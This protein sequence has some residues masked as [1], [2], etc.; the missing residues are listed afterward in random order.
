MKR[1]DMLK[2]IIAELLKDN[3]FYGL[4]A[5]ETAESILSMMESGG[6]LPPPNRYRGVSNLYGI[7]IKAE[8]DGIHIEPGVK[9]DN[10]DFWEPEDI[11]DTELKDEA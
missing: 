2:K 4:K 1:S 6:V 5:V 3:E 11:T 10:K 9:Y 7:D 8:Y